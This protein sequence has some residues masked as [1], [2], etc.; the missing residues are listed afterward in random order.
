M[1]RR[2]RIDYGVDD[3]TDLFTGLTWPSIFLHDP[4]YALFRPLYD[5][6]SPWR[7]SYDSLCLYLN[8]QARRLGGRHILMGQFSKLAL[9]S[10][11]YS[12]LHN[13]LNEPFNPKHNL[14]DLFSEVDQFLRWRF[15]YF[16]YDPWQDTA[17]ETN[18]VK[19]PDKEEAAIPYQKKRKLLKKALSKIPWQQQ[20]QK[21][22][23]YD[24]GIEGFHAYLIEKAIKECPDLLSQQSNE[25]IVNQIFSSPNPLLTLNFEGKDYVV[26]EV[27]AMIGS[28]YLSRKIQKG[29]FDNRG[30]KF[31]RILGS[32]A[33]WDDAKM[34]IFKNDDPQIQTQMFKDIKDNMS[35]ISVGNHKKAQVDGVDYHLSLLVD[36]DLPDR[37]FLI[38]EWEI[39]SQLTIV[40]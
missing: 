18:E 12:T 19:E 37:S 23:E 8:S 2:Q 29:W 31:Y 38:S 32:Y 14:S 7:S 10:T 40:L 22:L 28:H 1:A 11:R 9:I 35:L 24:S 15:D 3:S 20:L 13:F 34:V 39:N 6:T 16:S 5:R 17:P 30:K 27:P 36:S 33:R 26:G 21:S 25:D 4:T